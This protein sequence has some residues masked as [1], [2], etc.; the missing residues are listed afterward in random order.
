MNIGMKVTG[1]VALLLVVGGVYWVMNV[2]SKKSDIPLNRSQSEPTAS[3]KSPAHGNSGTGTGKTPGPSGGA[4][5]SAGTSGNANRPPVTPPRAEP[6]KTET[7]SAKPTTN[8]GAAQTDLPKRTEPQLPPLN[9]NKP[10]ETGG[11]A[12]PPATHPADAPRT[13]GGDTSANPS[14]PTTP[15]VTSEPP[16]TGGGTANPPTAGGTNPSSRGSDPGSGGTPITPP[17][18]GNTA[19]PPK[20]APTEPPTTPAPRSTTPAK[21]A[22]R[23]Y[24]VAAGDTLS[25]IALREYG[26]KKFWTKIR[27][28]NPTIDAD[29][30]SVGTQISLPSKEEVTGAPATPTSAARTNGNA[31]PTTPEIEEPP[32]VRIEREK[33]RAAA[34][35]KTADSPTTKPSP[36]NATPPVTAA[37]PPAKPSTG[38]YVVA[39]GDTLM[40][41]ARTVLK[42][43]K[44][45][46]EIYNLNKDRIKDPNNL[47]EGTALKL[48]GTTTKDSAP[49]SGAGST[50]SK[51]GGA[52]PSSAKPARAKP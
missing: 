39:K 6:P 18:A 10:A 48:P 22:A 28:A 37:P 17:G 41:I 24:V 31:P 30:L 49:A 34:R 51:P 25:T 50:G 33:E 2:P 45:W 1:V 21:P 4:K 38:T 23:N 27:A 12:A 29:K 8:P 9:P 11:S 19:A 44:R 13:S 32:S 7:D 26:D 35:T 5:P 14:R 40:R 47:I 20:P 43:E 3:N 52:K 42:D 15:G 46:R 16:A 36:A